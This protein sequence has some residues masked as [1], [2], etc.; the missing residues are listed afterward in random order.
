MHYQPLID[1]QS[2]RCVGVEA[3]LRWTPH[4]I[5]QSPDAFIS[6]LEQHHLMPHLTHHLMQLI[7]QDMQ[8]LPLDN[9]PAGFRVSVNISPI[10]STSRRCWITPA[11]YAKRCRHKPA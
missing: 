4:G 9:L 5:T 10:T 1:C 3:L 8:R 6:Q 2:G 7:A 11:P